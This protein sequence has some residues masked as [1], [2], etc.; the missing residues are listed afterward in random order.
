MPSLQSKS[1]GWVLLLLCVSLIGGGGAYARKLKLKIDKKALKE[2]AE[3][4]KATLH[5]ED[6]IACSVTLEGKSAVEAVRIFGYD[7]PYSAS[8]ESVFVTSALAGD[9]ITALTVQIDYLTIGN[10]NLHSR[11]LGLSCVIPPG[12]T[13]R[14]QFPSWD[15]THTFYYYRTPPARTPNLTPYKVRLTPVALTIH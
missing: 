11:T 8:K 9:T 3:I 6:S 15:A 14:L 7:K 12:K 2:Q 13:S 1:K 10:D 4:D 5:Q